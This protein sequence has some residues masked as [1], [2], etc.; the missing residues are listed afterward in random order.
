[1][2][3]F[4]NN[5]VNLLNLHYAIHSIALGG[6]G[7]FY[8]VYLLKA[9]VSVPGVLGVLAA[10]L[11]GRFIMRPVVI[12]IG[13]RLGMRAL[14]IL[15]TILSALQ[16]PLVAE[17]HG[18]GYP[19]LA[20]VLVSGFADS[21]YWSSYHA[22]FAALGDQE[23]RGQQIGVREAIASVIGIV[24]PIV[25]GAMLVTFG[26]RIAFGTTA[27]V[28]MLAALP[29][30]YTPDVRVQRHVPGAF[31]AAMPGMLLFVSDGWLC[32][33]Y[34]FVWQIALFISLGES[35]LA[36]GGAL[37]VAAVAGAIG[38]M[39]LGRHIDMGNGG[40]AVLVAYSGVLFAIALRAVAL[41]YPALAVF[42]NAVG[43]LEACLYI[44]TLMTAVYNQ[45]KQSPCTLRFHMMAEGGWDIGGAAGC[46][47]TATLAAL[48]VPLSIGI[49]TAVAGAALGFYLLRDYYARHPSVTVEP[50]TADMALAP[51]PT[52]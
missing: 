2:A 30:L 8:I 52:A 37:A 41:G 43:S 7:A 46:L 33:G 21:I 48:Q 19:L 4:R 24:S 12:P 16:Y 28:L 26:P 32:A 42:A 44:P 45:A 5:T 23:H 14:V 29:I 22:Y 25:G 20:L 15:G 35:F 49:L 6:G 9:G 50:A 18:I 13:A 3:F 31:R 10:I 40:R 36:Y 38:G 27:V 47:V 11:I 39:L 17:V 34:Y 51:P 1:M